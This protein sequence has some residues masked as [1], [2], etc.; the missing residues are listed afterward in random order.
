MRTKGQVEVDISE[1]FVRFEKEYMGRGPEETRTYVF[2]DMVL[3]RLRGVL[4]PAEKNLAKI[5]PSAHGRS[6]IKQVRIELLEKARPLLEEIIQDVTGQAVRSL[7]T[8]I[9]TATGERV[10][11]FT[12]DGRPDMG[13]PGTRD[14]G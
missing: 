10:V 12:L 2:D 1:A 14:Q 7:H 11:L 8:D 9:S 3:V 5:D 6:L 4:T 13:E